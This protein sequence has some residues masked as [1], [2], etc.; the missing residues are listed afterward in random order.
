MLIDE[1]RRKKVKGYQDRA[2]K[3]KEDFHSCLAQ[4][5]QD[6]K[7][8]RS[9][10]HPW[11]KPV[12]ELQGITMRRS[13]NEMVELSYH[14][15]H[16]GLPQ[17][18]AENEND[19]KKFLDELVSELKKRFKKLSGKALELKKVSENTNVQKYSHVFAEAQPLFGQYG[20][21]NTGAWGRFYV[22]Y[23]RVYELENPKFEYV[24]EKFQ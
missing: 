14:K 17:S 19:Q 10:E 1:A 6:L 9:M 20:G 11:S 2:Y 22:I 3:Q 4:A 23:S 21:L 8:E 7:D 15:I 13:G 12:Q 5:L 16:I 24:K 18:L